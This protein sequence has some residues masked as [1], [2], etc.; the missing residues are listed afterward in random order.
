MCE[1]LDSVLVWLKNQP[2]IRLLQHYQGNRPPCFLL[3]APTFTWRPYLLLIF[4]WP[5]HSVRS[6]GETLCS[7]IL[8][9]CLIYRRAQGKGQTKTKLKTVASNWHSNFREHPN[10][11]Q[12]LRGAVSSVKVSLGNRSKTAENQLVTDTFPTVRNTPVSRFGFL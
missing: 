3:W 10:T 2:I 4:H 7:Q 8:G 5:T 11:T 6:F 9:W 1:A 12:F